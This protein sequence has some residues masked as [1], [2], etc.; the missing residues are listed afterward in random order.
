LFLTSPF[1]YHLQLTYRGTVRARLVQVNLLS[2]AAEEDLVGFDSDSFS[3]AHSL[4]T[5]AAS[6]QE[7]SSVMDFVNFAY[8]VEAT[9]TAPE[10]TIGNPAKIAAVKVFASPNFLS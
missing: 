10:T 8:Y 9:L 4:V 7:D 5:N 6:A 2:G 1:H 3:P